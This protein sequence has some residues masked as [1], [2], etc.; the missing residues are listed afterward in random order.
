[1]PM[2]EQQWQQIEKRL[3]LVWQ[4]VDLDCDGYRLTL[5]LEQV[6]TY[7]NAIAVYVDGKWEGRWIT[8]DCEQRR[9]FFCPTQ[10]RVYRKGD[11]KGISKATL[12]HWR[13]DL[14]KRFTHYKPYWTSFARLRRH[15]ERNNTTITFVEEKNT[16]A[17]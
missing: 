14:N 5:V 2:N 9:R 6:S 13:V 16:E 1:M 10:G 3:E 11:F 15:L 17:A 4:F 7:K 12:K 8:E